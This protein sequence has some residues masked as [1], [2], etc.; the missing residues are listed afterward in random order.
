MSK[1]LVN[2]P[3]ILDLESFVNQQYQLE[4]FKMVAIQNWK[5]A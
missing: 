2:T 4:T 1:F 3:T 5:N